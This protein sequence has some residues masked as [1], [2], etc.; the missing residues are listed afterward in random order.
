M[1]DEEIKQIEQGYYQ[2]NSGYWFTD[3]K[4]LRGGTYYWHRT[5]RESYSNMVTL[6]DIPESFVNQFVRQTVDFFKDKDRVP[7][8]YVTATTRPENLTQS[9]KETG[10]TEAF[11]EAWMFWEGKVPNHTLPDGLTITKVQTSQQKQQF[12]KVFQRAYGG[13]DPSDPYGA[14]SAETMQHM[15]RL[16]DLPDNY[17]GKQTSH[18]LAHLNNQPV[19]E[20]TAIAQNKF[21]VI[22]ELGTV[23]EARQKGI[24]ASL[25]YK[26]IEHLKQQQVKYIFLITEAG[27]KLESYYHKLGFVT[28]FM[29]LSLVFDAYKY[30]A[31][32]AVNVCMGLQPGEYAVTITDQK[33]LSAAQY[34][35]D[36][37]NQTT[38]RHRIFMI[39]E[40]TST[41]PFTVNQEML[42]EMSRADA[43]FI[44]ADYINGEVA[45]FYRPIN[46]LVEQ[47]KKKMVAMVGLE[48]SQLA[49]GMNADYHQVK[50]LSDKLYH[51]IR[52]AKSIHVTTKRGTDFTVKT[53]YKW[54]VLDG[55]PK[56]GKWV[57]LPDGE[58]FTCPR[59]LDGT[60]VID[61]TVEF[62]SLQSTHPITL[63]MKDNQAVLESIHCQ[64]M[65][66]EQKFKDYLFK[67]DE[68]SS[69]IGEFAFG[70]NT[71][72]HALTGNLLQDEKI[73]SVHVA[74]GDPHGTLTGATWTSEL[75][76][77]C[78]ILDTTVYA[79][80]ACIMQ[81]G[82]YLL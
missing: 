48:K 2:I 27:T 67:T 58:V 66:I 25:T 64:N 45:T 23:V 79:D 74:F 53:G 29:G 77:D 4:K 30:G 73:P 24:G 49:E 34:I 70:T 59:S 56:P 75:H 51:K 15:R 62:L 40:Y 69:K 21:G 82:R 9:L 35:I 43:I 65:A 18:F 3:T 60:I 7:N 61:G 8:V 47:H 19:G 13:E 46:E 41:S 42:K 14:L 20:I 32:Q 6:V 76:I 78:I 44:I 50:S 52:S 16:L 57:N 10:F 72:I 17:Q 37:I 81:D 1:T 71:F 12:A 39:N 54:G 11:H 28:K 63:Q 26:A 22:Y 80:G 68:N 36:Q 38:D 31:Y 55:F 5:V 33:T